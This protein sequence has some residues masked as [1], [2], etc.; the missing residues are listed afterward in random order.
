MMAHTHNLYAFVYLNTGITSLAD[1]SLSPC[2]HGGICRTTPLC[3]CCFFATGI[4]RT[5]TSGF[6]TGSYGLNGCT[7]VIVFCTGFLIFL[8]TQTTVTMVKQMRKAAPDATPINTS[9]LIVISER[10]MTIVFKYLMKTTTT[11]IVKRVKDTFCIIDT[12]F[13]STGNILP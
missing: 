2:H 13:R 4:L 1:H 5:R 9:R 11:K 6:L 7:G 3:V 10:E 8:T 12:G